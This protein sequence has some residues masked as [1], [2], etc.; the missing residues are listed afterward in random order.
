MY[1]H[2]LRTSPP[3][4]DNKS[5]FQRTWKTDDRS[6]S[7]HYTPFC[8]TALF[9]QWKLLLPR[10]HIA[11]AIAIRRWLFQLYTIEQSRWNFLFFIFLLEKYMKKNRRISVI[12]PSFSI[13]RT[14]V[15][16]WLSARTLPFRLF[17]S[18]N[19]VWIRRF[20]IKQYFLQIYINKAI[21]Y[22]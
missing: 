5:D 7:A 9:R 11:S 20:D 3:L 19:S 1:L 21:N 4:A 15:T 17:F 6:I 12:F 2:I 14:V 16:R 8:I 18:V 10:P 22:T 13:S